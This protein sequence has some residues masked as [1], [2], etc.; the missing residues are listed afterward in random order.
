MLSRQVQ[1]RTQELQQ[2]NIALERA[3]NHDF[4]TDLPNRRVFVE[5][6]N[7]VIASNQPLAPAILDLDYF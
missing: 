3:A 2:A 7:A 1:E 6:I 5:S 4:L